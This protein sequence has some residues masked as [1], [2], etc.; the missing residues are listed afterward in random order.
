MEE[1]RLTFMSFINLFDILI[2]QCNFLTFS[3][4]L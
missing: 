1:Q 3:T 4:P 2:S